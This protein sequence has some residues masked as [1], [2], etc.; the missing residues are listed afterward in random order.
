MQNLG[1]DLDHAV[2]HFTAAAES[3]DLPLAAVV[4]GRTRGEHGVGIG[5]SL[6]D[7][8]AVHRIVFGTDPAATLV[9][10]FADAWAEGAIGAL[11]ARGALDHR[12]GLAT[13]DYLATRLRDLARTGEAASRVLVLSAPPVPPVPRIAALIRSARVAQEL[14]VSFPEAE[15]PVGLDDRTRIAAIV[16]HDDALAANLARARIAIGTV[17]GVDRAELSALDLP[18]AESAVPPFLLAL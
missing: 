17:D 9:R 3:D 13:V 5:P 16:P 2:A 7:L 14:A 10:A 6:D 4:L 15:T 1:R 12:T 11:L 18:V 8:E